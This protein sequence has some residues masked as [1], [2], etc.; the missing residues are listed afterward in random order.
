[1]PPFFTV[2]GINLGDMA[3]IVVFFLVM[4]LVMAAVTRDN[5]SRG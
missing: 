4:V 3:G 5:D 1:M 2:G